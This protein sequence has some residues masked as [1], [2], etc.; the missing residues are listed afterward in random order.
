MKKVSV[1]TRHAITN[2]GSLLQS[3]ATQKMIE[4]MGY[5]CEIVNYIRDDE[6]YSKHELTLLKKKPNWYNNPV[7]RMTYLLLRQPESILAGRKFEKVRNETLNLSKLYTTKKNCI[8]T[9]Q[10]Q[11]FI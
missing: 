5:E 7:K 6:S 2:Y 8:I 4:K 11:M 9:H 3:L 10:K 1:I